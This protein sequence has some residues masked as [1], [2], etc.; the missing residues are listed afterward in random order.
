[1]ELAGKL[2]DD[3]V[4]LEN[5]TGWAEADPL[6]VLDHDSESELWQEDLAEWLRM[7]DK[8][9]YQAILLGSNDRLLRAVFFRHARWLLTGTDADVERLTR[10]GLSGKPA[11][12]EILNSLVEAN[13][14]ARKL[15]WSTIRI[16]LPSLPLQHGDGGVF[17]DRMRQAL[18]QFVGDRP[19]LQPL[20]VPL[21]VTVL[22]VPPERPPGRGRTGKHLG[23]KDLDNVLIKVLTVLEQELQ[24][25]PEPWLLLPEIEVEGTESNHRGAERALRHR[26]LTGSKT[27]A[28][29]VFELHRQPSDPPQGSLVV[30]PGLGWNRRSIWEEAE[31]FVGQR[32]RKLLDA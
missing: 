22:V 9:R 31:D 13:A 3:P 10:M 1:M 21:R 24:P 18:R 17:G 27:W 14:E 8:S 25:H 20:L 16:E 12:G 19:D 29:Q 6:D 30:V 15:L 11:V 32:L 4:E 5:Q 23:G 28:Y 7:H 26:S 2:L